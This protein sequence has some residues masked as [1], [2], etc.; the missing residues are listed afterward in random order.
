M[1]FFQA[2]DAW[3]L[4]KPYRGVG[5]MNLNAAERAVAKMAFA[6]TTYVG[7]GLHVG[8]DRRGAQG[9]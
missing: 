8:V 2:D 7:R 1:Q 6:G 4:G 3:K 9:S 5:G